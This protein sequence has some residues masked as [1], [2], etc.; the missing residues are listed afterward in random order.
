MFSDVSLCDVLLTSLAS[1]IHH[2]SL[3]LS[4]YI[5]CFKFYCILC[6]NFYRFIE[7]HKVD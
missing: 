6:I 4:V 1:M 7:G 3:L 5:V 2:L